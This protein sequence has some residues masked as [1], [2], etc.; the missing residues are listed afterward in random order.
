MGEIVVWMRGRPR[1]CQQ[2][3]TVSGEDV[4]RKIVK[5]LPGAQVPRRL[6]LARDDWKYWDD[7]MDKEEEETPVP[8]EKQCRHCLH[9]VP[10]EAPSCAW[11]GKP[12]D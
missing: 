4:K 6:I 7:D 9:W 2:A 3:Y 5:G 12:F 11:C 8:P 10:S 1:P